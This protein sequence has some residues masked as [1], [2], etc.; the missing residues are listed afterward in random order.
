MTHF[1]PKSASMSALHPPQAKSAN[2][3]PT[4]LPSKNM[5]QQLQADD[6]VFGLCFLQ[7]MQPIELAAQSKN[8]I[9]DIKIEKLK[10]SRPVHLPEVQRGP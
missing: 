3:D 2:S 8:A 1:R 4:N 6:A 5:Q 9:L 10:H 7:Q